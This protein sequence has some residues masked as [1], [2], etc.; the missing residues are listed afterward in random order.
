[1]ATFN[2]QLDATSI[3]WA[4]GELSFTDTDDGGGDQYQF[5]VSGTVNAPPPV[6]TVYDGGTAMPNDMYDGG[7][8]SDD[9]GSTQ[10][11][12]P[13]E[14]V[15]TISNSSAGDISVSNLSLPS[16]F[17]LVGSFPSDVPANGSATFTVELDAT[18]VS[19]PNGELSFD[20]TDPGG[21]G[22]YQFAISG[23]VNG[24]PSM[25]VF[26]GSNQLFN[27]ASDDLG[28]ADVYG[29][30]GKSFDIDNVG[31]GPLTISSVD[32][33]SGISLESYVPMTIPAGQSAWLTVALDGQQGNYGGPLTIT[34][35]DSAN[36]PFVINLN[37]D[38][39][40]GGGLEVYDGDTQVNNG[41]DISFGQVALGAAAMK[42]LAF[43]NESTEP[44]FM[45][46]DYL[47]SPDFIAL[48]A[49]PTELA[50]GQSAVLPIEMNTALAGMHMASIS[51]NIEGE[52]GMS[53]T[54]TFEL[55][56]TVSSPFDSGELTVFDGQTQLGQTNDDFGT[57]TVGD[58]ATKSFTVEN[59]TSTPF[60][61]DSVSLPT[62]F[63]LQT[64]LPEQIAPGSSA[65]F[66]VAMDTSS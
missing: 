17:S 2:V 21:G 6:L 34:S 52:Y 62:G 35:D 39:V 57:F 66:T 31:T 47:E 16:G 51:V 19:S 46:A 12:T 5:A 61:L 27:G 7:M 49:L 59:P 55:D 1:S 10:L 9:F 20:D 65:S 8:S 22:S 26:D 23:T 15:F 42:L 32:T 40:T 54:F 58:R 29:G 24:L 48:Q 33:P 60:S 44:I 13:I 18:S 41:G 45:F 43:T 28:V 30:A 38:V 14:K 3:G 50:P 64:I 11:G 25:E 56:G 63:Q 36:N 4:I 53:D 37:G